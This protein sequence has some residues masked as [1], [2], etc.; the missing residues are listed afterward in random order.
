[1]TAYSRNF[2]TKEIIPARK[3]KRYTEEDFFPEIPQGRIAIFIGS[4]KTFSEKETQSIDDFCGKFDAVVFTSHISG[5]HG[6]YKCNFSL[7]C[8]QKNYFSP[9]R[10][11][12]W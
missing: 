4:H 8:G 5:Y 2:T 12:S 6:K 3:I 7:V 10:N 1:M 11:T 9:L